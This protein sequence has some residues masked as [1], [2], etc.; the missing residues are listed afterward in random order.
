M[1]KILNEEFKR[2]IIKLS[3]DDIINIVREYQNSTQGKTSYEQIR[4][5]LDRINLFIPEDLF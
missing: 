1:A 2:R 3:T 5:S 4:S